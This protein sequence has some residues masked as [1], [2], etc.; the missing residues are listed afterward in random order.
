MEEDPAFLILKTLRVQNALL[1]LNEWSK[2]ITITY[3][4]D[5][6]SDL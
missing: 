4:I 1:S 2:Y 5:S 6:F 3:Y